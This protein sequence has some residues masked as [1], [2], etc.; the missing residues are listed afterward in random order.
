MDDETLA[1]L[2]QVVKD[3]GGYVNILR[4]PDGKI[5]VLAVSTV[6]MRKAYY[7]AK[8]T[9]IQLDN[10][11][12]IESSNYK[13]HALIYHNPTTGLGEVVQFSF[14]ADETADSFTHLL[15]TFKDVGRS[16]PKVIL[17]DKV[18]ITIL[19]LLLH[20]P[21]LEVAERRHRY[22]FGCQQQEVEHQQGVP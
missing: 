20:A 22:S 16:I 14:M 15:E 4:F 19:L 21:Y 17:I 7:G 3:K 8:P 18:Q 12:E 1:K 13:L 2:L 9:F 6:K 10:T 11:F 5:R